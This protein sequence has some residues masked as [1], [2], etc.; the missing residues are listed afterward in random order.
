MSSIFGEE[1]QHP[2]IASSWNEVG[3]ALN[4]NERFRPILFSVHLHVE[5]PA[6]GDYK[7]I[8]S[9]QNAFI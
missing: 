3:L 4:A 2:N 9:A 6:S 1:G 5:Y 7:D 8:K